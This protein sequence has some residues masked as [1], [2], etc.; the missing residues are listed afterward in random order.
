MATGIL[1]AYT[2]SIAD[3]STPGIVHPADWL[4]AHT[5]AAGM[6]LNG[7][8][9]VGAV[10]P[11]AGLTGSVPAGWLLCN[12]DGFDRVGVYAGLYAAIGTLYGAP[13]GDHFS[14]PD[15]RDKFI[16]GANQDSGGLPK[17]NITGGLT[18]S[19]S[20][21]SVALTHSMTIAA[22]TLTHAGMAI[23]DHAALAHTAIAIADHPA[24][25][26][27][28]TIGN[29]G[30][31]TTFKTTTVTKVASRATAATAAAHAITHP[32]R[33]AITNTP[34]VALT[35][36]AAQTHDVTDAGEHG[37]AGHVVHSFTPPASQTFPLPAPAFLALAYMVRYL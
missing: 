28:V 35:T 11:F 14:V 33:A 30:A 26:A 17:A 22:H 12:G 16:V 5:V 9:P 19:Y 4:A 37:G 20:P 3:V 31:V 29:H 8:A 7:L 32:A 25:T 24:Y 15:L 13:D 23:A 36:H 2:N 1:H 21:A 27:S 6:A 18:Q 34:S 10:C